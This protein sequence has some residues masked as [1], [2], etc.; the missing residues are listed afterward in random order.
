MIL[1]IKKKVINKRLFDFYDC[2][3]K[4][5]NGH[6]CAW[7]I[8]RKKGKCTFVIIWVFSVGYLH[9]FFTQIAPTFMIGHVLERFEKFKTHTC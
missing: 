5:K 1:R 4:L 8:K 6:K 3:N 2:G 9:D 7:T